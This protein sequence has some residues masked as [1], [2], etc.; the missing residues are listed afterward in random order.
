[1]SL[2][3]LEW[4]L[5]HYINWKYDRTTIIPVRLIE[6]KNERRTDTKVIR[7]A[8]SDKW[9]EWQDLTQRSVTLSWWELAS[10]NWYSI[11]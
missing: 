1:M 5:S 2:S 9:E 6:K 8:I 11:C 3:F 4:K 7:N 10:N